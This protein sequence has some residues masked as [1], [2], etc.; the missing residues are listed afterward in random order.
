MPDYVDKLL[1]GVQPTSEEW[2][3]LLVEAHRKEPSMSPAAFAQCQ[4]SQGFTSYEW[5]AESI[6]GL[7]SPSCV[8]D[9]ACGDGFLIPSLQTRLPASCSIIGVDMAD[10]GL[11]IARS[12]KLPGSVKFLKARAQDTGLAA[13]SVDAVVCHMG[14]MLMLPIEPV[15]DELVR[16]LKPG[17]LVTAVV[18][19]RSVRT[20]P[21]KEVLD[22]VGKT[23]HDK[24]PNMAS[25]VT[26]DPRSE[27]REG[28]E[29]LF[30]GKAALV[31]T[32]DENFGCKVDALGVWNQ[33]KNMYL[34]GGLP[35]PVKA[36]IQQRILSTFQERGAIQFE[37]ALRRFVLK[38]T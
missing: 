14:L 17:G 28:M 31:S 18:S 34:I 1:K 29:S 8:I 2:E 11:E 3:H 27:T 16:L 23:L 33:V 30:E 37:F 7:K 24:F 22:I 12:R 32:E 36:V 6:K 35:S 25:P 9:L 26:G 13:G 20:G 19:N 21:F 5:A 4:N 15:V 10:S 38:K